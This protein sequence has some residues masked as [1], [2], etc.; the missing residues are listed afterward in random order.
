MFV[1]QRIVP[2]VKRVEFVGDG[3]KYKNGDADGMYHV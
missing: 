2:G 3:M 1:H